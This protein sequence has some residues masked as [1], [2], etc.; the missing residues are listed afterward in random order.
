MAKALAVFLGIVTFV[1]SVCASS[2]EVGFTEEDLKSEESLKG[3]YEK[4]AAQHRTRALDREE[5][6]RR[7]HVFKENVKH[8]D[9]VNKK[10]GP[11]QLR[12]N[13]FADL[14]NEEFKAKYL[15]LKVDKAR[16]LRHGLTHRVSDSFIYEGSNQIPASIDWRKKAAV[17]PVK[18]QGQCGSCWAFSTVVAVEGINAIKSG[19]LVSLSEQQLVDCDSTNSGCNGGIMDNAFKYIMETG[20]LAPEDVYPYMAEESTCDSKLQATGLVT[21]DGY[22]DVP[23]NNEKALKKA[24]AAQPVSVAIEAGG[25]NF[26]FY[27]KGIFTGKC[28][29]QLDHGV[30]IVGYGSEGGKDYWIVRNSWGADW[31]ESGYVRMQRNVDAP[32]GLC[33]IAMMASYPTKK[34]RSVKPD[35][36]LPLMDEL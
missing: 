17:S 16:M 5:H 28:G 6:D 29:T 27:H 24:V 15:G 36:E 21:I 9:S 34:G 12:L 11:Y 25:S 14:T 26:Q 32:E 10:K 2:S 13:K 1:A 4:W 19:K 8:I 31:G 35:D 18:N 23:P 3:L 22:K 7:F 20:G 33:G 30:A